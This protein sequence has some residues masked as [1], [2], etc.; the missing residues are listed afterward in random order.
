MIS[1][2]WMAG[3]KTDKVVTGLWQLWQF[4]FLNLQQAGVSFNVTQK[5]QPVQ[6]ETAQLGVNYCVD[7]SVAQY[8]QV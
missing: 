3:K 1:Q 5:N 7:L 6:C 2:D 8:L 4:F